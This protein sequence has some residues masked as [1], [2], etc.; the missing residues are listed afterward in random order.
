MVLGKGM[1]YTTV[2]PVLKESNGE[3]RQ[4]NKHSGVVTAD[5][6]ENVFKLF[7]TFLTDS[8]KV[9]SAIHVPFKQYISTTSIT[10]PNEIQISH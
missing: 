9:I 5:Q 7:V 2:V 10:A 6:R 4:L 3:E 8:G 1:M